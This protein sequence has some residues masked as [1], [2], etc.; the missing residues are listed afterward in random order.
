[1]PK[2]PAADERMSLSTSRDHLSKI[3]GLKDLC[4][5][6]LILKFLNRMDLFFRFSNTIMGLLYVNNGLKL[7]SGTKTQLT[8]ISKSRHILFQYIR[9]ESGEGNDRDRM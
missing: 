5:R 3:C 6:I 8:E 1:M 4:L 7:L 2:V 9:Y